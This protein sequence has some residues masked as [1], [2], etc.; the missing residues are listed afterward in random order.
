MASGVF[1]K[2]LLIFITRNGFALSLILKARVFETRKWPINSCSSVVKPVNDVVCI[3]WTAPSS[4]IVTLVSLGF[5]YLV[6]TTV[7]LRSAWNRKLLFG[8]VMFLIV[9][10]FVSSQTYFILSFLEGNFHTFAVLYCVERLEH[11]TFIDVYS[12]H[13]FT[14][15]NRAHVFFTEEFS[16]KTLLGS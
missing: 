12:P 14:S 13:N 4:S 16:I 9:Y 1:T 11:S 15:I 5:L 8:F 6:S 10:T 3:V 2:P 7:L